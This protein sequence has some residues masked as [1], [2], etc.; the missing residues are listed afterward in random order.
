MTQLHAVCLS[1]LGKEE[2]Q[3]RDNLLGWEEEMVEEI[4]G[5][6]SLPS[7]E[8]AHCL[9]E[10]AEEY[11]DQNYLPKYVPIKQVVSLLLTNLIESS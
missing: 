1:N 7:K 2:S 9:V 11:P 4:L 6:K 10:I 8:D 3:D 5:S